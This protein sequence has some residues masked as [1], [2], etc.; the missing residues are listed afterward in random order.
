MFI[1]ALLCPNCNRE[2]AKGSVFCGNCGFRLPQT[3]IDYINVNGRIMQDAIKQKY[4]LH[5]DISKLDFTCKQLGAEKNQLENDIEKLK[6]YLDEELEKLSELQTETAIHD[7]GFYKSRYNFESSN[8]YRLRLN[9]IRERQKELIRSKRATVCEAEWTVNNSRVQGRKQINDTFKLMLFAF[10]GEADVV[11]AKVKFKNV[12]EAE[13]R[14]KKSFDLINKLVSTQQAYIT[15]EYLNLKLEELYLAHEYQEKLYDEKEEQRRI[16]EQIREEEIARR[17]IEKALQDAE[18][19]ETRYDE[20]LRKAREEVE[21][22]AGDKQ[23]KLLAQI[24]VLQDRLTEIQTNKE[25]A[26]S[27]AQMTRSGH[28]YVISNIGSFG[29]DIYK[30]GMTRRLDPMDRVIELGDA[31][32]P[33]RFDVHAIIYSDDAPTLENQLHRKF[34]NRRINLVNNRKEFFRVSLQEIAD[35]VHE[36]HG[37]IEF[38]LAAEAAEYRKTL[39]FIAERQK[40]STVI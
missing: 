22:V 12:L 21:K 6:P 13:S 8:A 7:L 30:I 18:R 16:R 37:E 4:Q 20:A 31:S 5:I 36:Y 27:R 19:E 38:T 1:N 34:D 15:Q 9:A 39:A 40:Q 2:N 33:F 17:E 24:Q 28:V 23:A 3:P 29:E 25:R 11:I 14:I 10:N 32:V 35:A 26:L